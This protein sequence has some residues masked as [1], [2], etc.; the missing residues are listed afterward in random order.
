MQQIVKYRISRTLLKNSYVEG[1]IK[2][3]DKK[4]SI[5]FHI[6][7]RNSDHIT[8][9]YR[10]STFIFFW[11]KCFLNIASKDIHKENHYLL[12]VGDIVEM[13]NISKVLHQ[14]RKWKP[15]AFL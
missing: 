3:N 13:R 1:I 7:S 11:L 9:A 6:R 14:R 5:K 12:P 10:H 15:R 8:I 2:M 4:D